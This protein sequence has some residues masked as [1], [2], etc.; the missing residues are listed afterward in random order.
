MLC[1]RDVAVFHIGIGRVACAGTGTVASGSK[2]SPELTHQ[3]PE[4]TKHSQIRRFV[5]RYIVS[6]LRHHQKIDVNNEA[7]TCG[8]QEKGPGVWCARASGF[9]GSRQRKAGAELLSGYPTA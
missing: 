3:V 1:D 6:E 5:S 4:I 8:G 7:A 2:F 9:T